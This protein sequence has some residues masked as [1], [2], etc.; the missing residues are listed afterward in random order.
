MQQIRALTHEY[1]DP[2][3]IPEEALIELN[4]VRSTSEEGLVS[5]VP[6]EVFALQAAKAGTAAIAEQRE[7]Y[8]MKTVPFEPLTITVETK[9]GFGTSLTNKQV[10]GQI[11]KAFE[12]IDDDFSDNEC[13]DTSVSWAPTDHPLNVFL[14]DNDLYSRTALQ[15]GKLYIAEYLS[16]NSALLSRNA[17]IINQV[18]G[19]DYDGD[20]D[21]QI[22]DYLIDDLALALEHSERITP[23]QAK[24][25]WEELEHIKARIADQDELEKQFVSTFGDMLVDREIDDELK[26]QGQDVYEKEL[27]NALSVDA[28][29]NLVGTTVTKLRIEEL[30][31]K[32]RVRGF[33]DVADNISGAATIEDVRQLL[34]DG[35]RTNVVAAKYKALEKE[36]MAERRAMT[37][38]QEIHDFNVRLH[39]LRD[40]AKTEMRYL[41]GAQAY[42][43]FPKLYAAA[44]RRQIRDVQDVLI[45][46]AGSGHLDMHLDPRFDAEKDRDPGVISGDC[47]AGTPLPFDT[48]LPAFNVKIE[49]GGEHKGNIYLLKSETR[50]GQSVWHLDAVQLP[51]F[52]VDWKKFPGILLEAIAPDAERSGIAYITIN[53]RPYYISNYDYIARGFLE[54]LGAENTDFS[55]E[56]M[57]LNMQGEEPTYEGMDKVYVKFP[58][59]VN[60]HSQFQGIGNKQLVLWRNPAAPKPYEGAY[61]DDED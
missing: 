31:D 22:G 59:V 53:S 46:K 54:Y 30:A 34:A 6:A 4:Y 50:D 57:E 7:A 49:I 43:D 3:A 16:I 13:D 52:T 40:R 37:E 1:G 15:D 55:Y 5:L 28:A 38:E 12:W 23:Q 18:S 41:L 36:L 21:R 19:G 44:V 39:E 61:Y 42:F 9:G 10:Q 26:D 24:D 25:L 27:A 32:L 29:G 60:D 8:G 35:V 14:R 58:P 51:N 2:A 45:Y 11:K 17:D 33:T 56:Q 48:R 20:P 47:T